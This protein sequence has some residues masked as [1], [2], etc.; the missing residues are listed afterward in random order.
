MATQTDMLRFHRNIKLDNTDEN[1]TLREK[2]DIVLQR[3]RD[4]GLRFDFFNQ[5]SYA[6]GTGVVPLDGDF[7]IDVGLIVRQVST[8]C[9]PTQLKRLVFDAAQWPNQQVTWHQNC[10]RVPWIKQGEPIYHVDLACYLETPGGLMRAVGKQHAQADQVKWEACDPLALVKMLSDGSTPEANAQRRRVIRYL[11]R[12][13]DVNF[14]A[15]GYARPPGVAITALVLANFQPVP[16]APAREGE[17]DDLG[18]LSHVVDRFL[19]SIL[20]YGPK[21]LRVNLPVTPRNDLLA[22]QTDEQQRQLVAKLEQLRA[23]LVTAKGVDDRALAAQ[24]GSAWG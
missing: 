10:I 2:R 21:P 20:F 22:K 24:L 8:D 3:L 4:R 1:Q 19:A 12:W 6:M 23:A 17:M 9:T 7:D 16:Y 11:K 18:A 5:G 14:Q 13:K 15:T